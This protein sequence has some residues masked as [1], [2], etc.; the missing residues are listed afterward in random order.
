MFGEEND[1]RGVFVQAADG[2]DGVGLLPKSIVGTYL[3]CQGVF[4]VA[5][6]RVS[7]HTCRFVDS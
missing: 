2:A 1:A 7:D 3:V 4:I 6:L 5:A